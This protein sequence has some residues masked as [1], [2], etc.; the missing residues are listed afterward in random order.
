MSGHTPLLETQNLC[1]FFGG[2]RA[3]DGVSVQINAREIFGIIGP[4]GAGKTT[5]LNLCSGACRVSSG[6][7]MFDGKNITNL[8]AHTISQAGIARTFQNIKLFNSMTVFDNVCAGFHN[9]EKTNLFDAL[10]R[11]RRFKQ[12]QAEVERRAFSLLQKLQL[13]EYKDML[14]KN[15]SYGMRRKVEIARAIATGP[16]LLLLDEPVAGMNPAE[17]R[18]LLDFIL[19]IRDEGWTIAVIEHDIKFIAQLCDRVMVLHYG[20]KLCEGSA[21]EVYKDSRVIEAYFGRG[22]TAR[23]A[24]VSNA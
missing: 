7:I 9:V 12:E 10:A 5:F 8:G 4:N 13:E 23:D 1:R 6:A 11:T 2:L 16:K 3:V 14:A 19:K 22:R 20:K 17:T 24:G 15:L 21:A 18:A